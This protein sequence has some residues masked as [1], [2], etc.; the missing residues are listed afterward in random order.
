MSLKDLYKTLGVGK[1]ATQTEIKSAYRKGAKRLHPDNGGPA[2]AFAELS[3]AYRVL[4]DDEKRKQYDAGKYNDN[5]RS[6]RTRA[7]EEIARRFFAALDENASDPIMH[8]TKTI[9]IEITDL[10]ARKLMTKKGIKKLKAFKKK[11][12]SKQKENIFHDIINAY[13]L[14]AEAAL[15]K[16]D[17]DI[18]FR[19]SV[20]KM[21]EDYEWQDEMQGDMKRYYDRWGTS[22][23]HHSFTRGATS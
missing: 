9:S 5:P 3:L 16:I 22:P 2:E 4:S 7:I 18:E 15:V 10:T 11:I 20:R 13:V 21:L 14:N 1:K 17:T 12:I 23:H 8:I 19:K 6:E